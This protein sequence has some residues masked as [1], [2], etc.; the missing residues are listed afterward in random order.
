MAN[1]RTLNDRILKTLKPAEP[2]KRYEIKDTV[3]PG[4]WVRVT[5]K[6]H[7]TF[8]LVARFPGSTNPTRGKLGD[9][10]ALTLE[11]A[12]QKARG[13][14]DRISKG[15]DPRE[16]EERQRAAELR[17]RQNTF[18]SVAEDFIK[19][20]VVR[21]RKAD[22]VERD[23]RRE[24]ISRWGGLP[25]T[26]IAKA[27]VIEMVKATKERGK[28]YQAHNLLSTARRLFSWAVDQHVYG[29]EVSPCAPLKAKSL[30]G[31][32]KPRKRV[33][34]N[35]EMR[36]LWAAADRMG[37]PYGPLYHLLCLTGLRRDDVGEARWSEFDIESKLWIIPADRMKMDVAHTVP[38]TDGMMG[39][40][41]SLPRFIKGDFLFSTRQG[42]KPVNGFAHAKLKLDAMMEAELGTKLAEFI[43]HDIR[44]TMR[45]H[46]SALPEVPDLVRELVIAHAKKGQHRVYD[47]YEYLPE[48]R[49]ALELWQARLREIVE[50]S[51]KEP[52]AAN[53][54]ALRA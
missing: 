7:R 44:R 1:K 24:F 21:E 16:E 17:K 8:I 2:G 29:L 19:E 49:K 26:Q 5:D 11:Q 3:V 30:I 6:G 10:G 41:K 18:A 35:D 4:F 46:L 48:K 27:H 42:A 43:N 20:K 32:K 37:Y 15:I 12:R 45:T 9:Y 53:V 14:L 31:E 47:L 36:A 50:P 51:S 39:I 13:W 23:I 25:I 33:L 34:T 54:V 28:F 22:E 38:L 52:P 40:L